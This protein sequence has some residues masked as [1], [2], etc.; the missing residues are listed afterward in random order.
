MPGRIHGKGPR[1]LQGTLSEILQRANGTLKD[2]ETKKEKKGGRPARTH[3]PPEPGGD[4]LVVSP[5]VQ[6]K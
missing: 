6:I 4:V 2:I 1:A 5:C 3:C